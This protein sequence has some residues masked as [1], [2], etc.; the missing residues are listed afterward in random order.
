VSVET[1]AGA[2]IRDVD[3][4]PDG[5]TAAVLVDDGI[6]LVDAATLGPLAAIP[7]DASSVRWL[8]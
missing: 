1:V 2:R 6:L 5:K 4:A 7:A 3:F 8:P